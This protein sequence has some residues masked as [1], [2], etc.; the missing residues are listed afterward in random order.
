M[1]LIP[2]TV[3]D[4]RSLP[5]WAKWSRPDRPT[6]RNAF[7]SIHLKLNAISGKEGTFLA[8]PSLAKPFLFRNDIAPS[9]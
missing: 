9:T 1:T 8:L 2:E 3:E 5:L 7:E 4:M 6:S